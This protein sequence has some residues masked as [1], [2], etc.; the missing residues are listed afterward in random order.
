VPADAGFLLPNFKNP[1]E[2]NIE[3]HVHPHALACEFAKRSKR[4]QIGRNRD[5]PGLSGAKLA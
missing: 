4:D 3:L 2:L 5:L 1:Q